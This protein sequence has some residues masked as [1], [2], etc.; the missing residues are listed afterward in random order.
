[1]LYS[2]KKI[3]IQ[4]KK[5]RKIFPKVSEKDGDE[6]CMPGERGQAFVQAKQCLLSLRVSVENLHQRRL[7]PYNANVLLK[8]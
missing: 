3:S 6:T 8:R 5:K 1:M 7:F 2:C 4:L